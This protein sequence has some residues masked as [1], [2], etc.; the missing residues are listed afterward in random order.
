MIEVYIV[1]QYLH[2]H[3]PCGAARGCFIVGAVLWW[4]VGL[5]SPSPRIVNS[6]LKLPLKDFQELYR[7]LFAVS[8]SSPFH[9][10]RHR[11]SC[12]TCGAVGIDTPLYLP[13][14]PFALPLPGKR[15]LSAVAAERRGPRSAAQLPGGQALPDPATL[16][17]PL[18]F[19]LLLPPSLS[20]HL[21]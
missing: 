14:S 16:R 19:S 15:L 3:K 10:C 5:S 21:S 2:L 6:P 8:L 9:T 20:P 7:W 12:L 18:G 17:C 4:F 1:E 11:L 13:A